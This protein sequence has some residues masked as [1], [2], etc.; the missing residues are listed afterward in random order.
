MVS[1][2]DLKKFLTEV[3][4]VERELKKK[5]LWLSPVLYMHDSSATIN[6]V[7]PGMYIELRCSPTHLREFL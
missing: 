5:I 3:L 7:L 6:R 2:T 1:G 4:F